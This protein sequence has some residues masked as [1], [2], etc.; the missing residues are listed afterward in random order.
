MIDVGWGATA[1]VRAKF[2]LETEERKWILKQETIMGGIL[3]VARDSWY[4]FGQDWYDLTY[5]MRNFAD[6]G[7]TPSGFGTGR[8]DQTVL[9]SL[10]YPLGLVIHKQDYTQQAPFFLETKDSSIPFYITWNSKYVNGNTI[11]YS[12][13]GDLKNYNE[14]YSS[15][16][17]K[18]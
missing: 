3:G 18:K 8:H 13:R 11:I 1:F 7:T 17:F 4:L 10:A 15:I 5:D 9:S 16:K 14:Y 12:S 6:D 2:C